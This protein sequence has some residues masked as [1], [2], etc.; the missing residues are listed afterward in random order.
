MPYLYELPTASFSLNRAHWH[1]DL[2]YYLQHAHISIAHIMW[3]CVLALAWLRH[4][5]ALNVGN[6]IVGKGINAGRCSR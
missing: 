5:Q 1:H 4:L 2:I 3:Q 6:V